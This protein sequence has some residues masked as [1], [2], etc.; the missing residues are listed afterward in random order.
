MQF[1]LPSME[2][3]LKPVVK[4]LKGDGKRS[5]LSVKVKAENT[6]SHEGSRQVSE[7]AAWTP[8]GIGNKVGNLRCNTPCQASNHQ[9]INS[10]NKNHHYVP[11]HLRPFTTVFITTHWG[12]YWNNF[13]WKMKSIVQGEYIAK[14]IKERGS[15]TRASIHLLLLQDLWH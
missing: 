4:P 13:L 11:T 1:Q 6:G 7:A 3:P 9:N 2:S 14:V 12:R 10:N 15:R 8:T 5:Q